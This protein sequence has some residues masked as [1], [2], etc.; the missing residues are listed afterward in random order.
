MVLPGELSWLGCCDCCEG[1]NRAAALWM[2]CVPCPGMGTA[3]SKPLLPLAVC[4]CGHGAQGP[5]GDGASAT[6]MQLSSCLE[7][8]HCLGLELPT[9]NTSQEEVRGSGWGSGHCQ[10]PLAGGESRQRCVPLVSLGREEG[11][12]RGSLHLERSPGET[13][14]KGQPIPKLP[15]SA[16]QAAA[17]PLLQTALEPPGNGN[18]VEVQLWF[19][20]PREAESHPAPRS[21]LQAWSQGWPVPTVGRLAAGRSCWLIQAV[22]ALSVPFWAASQE[23]K[24]LPVTPGVLSQVK[25]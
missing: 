8:F 4:V 24:K 25:A 9:Q 16:R 6:Q 21:C 22:V 23:G 13:S 20:C 7:R 10:P 18:C 19:L 2:G 5:V 1:W 3:G 17:K 15:A 12:Q 14:G 11:R